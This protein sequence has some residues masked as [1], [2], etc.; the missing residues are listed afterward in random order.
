MKVTI[1]ITSDLFGVEI[2]SDETL[3]FREICDKERFIMLMEELEMPENYYIKSNVDGLSEYM[4][5]GKLKNMTPLKVDTIDDMDLKTY[6]ISRSK[7]S[8]VLPRVISYIIFMLGILIGIVIMENY[9]VRDMLTTREERILS[10]KS[11]L[12]FNEL[13]GENQIDAS[14]IYVELRVIY[15]PFRIELFRINFD[16][17]VEIM[18]LHESPTLNLMSMDSFSGVRLHRGSA[19]TVDDSIFYIYQLGGKMH[20]N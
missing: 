17:T 2:T 9:V 14:D 11:I 6:F 3:L 7:K 18:F 20:D 4:K 16:K 1:Y 13:Y 19:I 15:N 5:I 12:E 8:K 10:T